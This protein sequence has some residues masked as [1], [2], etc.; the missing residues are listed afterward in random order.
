MKPDDNPTI[1]FRIFLLYSATLAS[2]RANDKLRGLAAGRFAT[3]TL[4]LPVCACYEELLP[5]FSAYQVEEGNVLLFRAFF[6]MNRQLLAATAWASFQVARK[7]MSWTH[8][9]DITLPS[10]SEREN[11]IIAR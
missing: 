11:H 7:I 1:R 10:L 3:R 4:N 5:A 8:L 9:A 6:S 2:G